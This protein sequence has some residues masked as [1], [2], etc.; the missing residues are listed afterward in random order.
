MAFY[1]PELN[2][3]SFKIYKALLAGRGEN[4]FPYSYLERET[5]MDRGELRELLGIHKKLGIIQYARGLMNEEGEVA[6]SG[7]GIPY[8]DAYN[9]AELACYKYLYGGLDKTSEPSPPEKIIVN[10][11]VYQALER[12]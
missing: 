1:V 6:G 8:G 2:E 7:F 5:G 9:S 4:Y 10:G 11:K 3:K 12:K